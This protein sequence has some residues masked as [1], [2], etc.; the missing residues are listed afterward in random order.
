MHCTWRGWEGECG[1]LMEKLNRKGNSGLLGE[2][3]RKCKAQSYKVNGVS[4]AGELMYDSSGIDEV[5]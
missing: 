2:V 4:N 3:G 1:G 5:E